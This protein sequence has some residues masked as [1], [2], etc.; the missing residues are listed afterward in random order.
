MN[1]IH[2]AQF[3][4]EYLHKIDLCLIISLPL[5]YMVTWLSSE[6]MEIKYSMQKNEN[7][8]KYEDTSIG[9]KQKLAWIFCLDQR[10]LNN[11]K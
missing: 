7:V 1:G 5:F 9:V 10:N 11:S 4:R 6:L 8:V 3:D 2:L